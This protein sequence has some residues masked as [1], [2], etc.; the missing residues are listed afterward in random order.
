[1]SSQ[2]QL[3]T[4]DD[5][6]HEADNEPD[7][8]AQRREVLEGGARY[9]RDPTHEGRDEAART[10]DTECGHCGGHVTPRFVRVFGVDGQVHA[11]LGCSEPADIRAGAAAY[12]L[13]ASDGGELR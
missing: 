9:G 2:G 1:M 4:L 8:E 6:H 7:L 3:T 12:G 13:T 11:C 5:R 10:M